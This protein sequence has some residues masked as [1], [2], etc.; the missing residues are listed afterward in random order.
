MLKQQTP[1]DAAED[2]ERLQQR[3]DEILDQRAQQCGTRAQD[4][5]KQAEHNPSFF[6][7][8]KARAARLRLSVGELAAYDRAKLERSEYPGPDCLQPFEVEEFRADRLPATRL[9]HI[10]QCSG[11]A[12]LLKALSPAPTGERDVIAAVRQSAEAVGG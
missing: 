7:A 1:H 5:L 6:N 3:L 9:A 12:G 4:V 8:A 11:C 10:N 2:V